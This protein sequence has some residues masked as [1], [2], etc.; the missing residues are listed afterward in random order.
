MQQETHT[1]THNETLLHKRK[2]KILKVSGKE[3]WKTNE[4]AAVRLKT[5]FKNIKKKINAKNQR[6][7]FK[8]QRDRNCQI[9]TPDLVKV[10]SKTEVNESTQRKIK[11]IERLPRKYIREG[12]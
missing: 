4:A 12:N 10:F 11:N 2:S 8:V 7:A 1:Y 6:N 3:E 9:R 5:D